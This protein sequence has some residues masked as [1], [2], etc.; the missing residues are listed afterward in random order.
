MKIALALE[1]LNLTVIE[2]KQ[3]HLNTLHCVVVSDCIRRYLT[4]LLLVANLVN[5]KWCNKPE[6]WLKPWHM[7]T[8]LRVRAIQWIPTWQGLNAFQKSLHPCPLEESSLSIER[9][10]RGSQRETLTHSH[11]ERPKQAWQFWWYFSYK[12]IFWKIFGGKILIRSQATTLLQIFC[13]LLFYS[14]V[15]SKSMKVADDTF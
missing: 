3:K 10:K 2:K 12:S 14:Q 5:T 8:H 13:E 4:L 7:G 9:V 6:K 15:I 11:L 1:G